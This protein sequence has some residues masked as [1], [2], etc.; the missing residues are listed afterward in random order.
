ME[1][2]STDDGGLKGEDQEPFGKNSK[3]M[4]TPPTIKPKRKEKLDKILELM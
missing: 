1:S 3:T 2:N 4:R